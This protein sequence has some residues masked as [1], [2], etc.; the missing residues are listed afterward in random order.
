[1]KTCVEQG[2]IYN[3]EFYTHI[4]AKGIMKQQ[5]ISMAASKF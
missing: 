3:G 2:V 5:I 1:M 4:E